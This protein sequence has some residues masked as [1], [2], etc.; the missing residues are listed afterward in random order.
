MTSMMKRPSIAATIREKDAGDGAIAPPDTVV[1]RINQDL[2]QAVTPFAL[3]EPMIEGC[4]Q[5][6]DTWADPDAPSYWLM[7]ARLNEAAILTAGN[8]ADHG[9]FSAAGDLLF[10][11]RRILAYVKDHPLPI[12]KNRHG[13]ISDQ[14]NPRGI[15]RNEF[16][17]WFQQNAV[18]QEV[19][20]PLLPFIHEKMRHSGRIEPGYLD[21]SYAKMQQVAD[22]ISFL[23]AWGVSRFET[24]MERRH[25]ADRETNRFAESRLCRFS[26]GDF[27]QMGEEIRRID[28][29]RRIPSRY[30]TW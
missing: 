24:L 6:L 5:R 29:N 23:G 25:H 3:T 4:L 21:D 16:F 14:F 1:S 8:Y 7:L 12:A 18:L 26:T 22:T 11:P 27:F 20:P 10:N 19:L 15:P 2:D 17:A 30:L 9:E 28:K 13:T